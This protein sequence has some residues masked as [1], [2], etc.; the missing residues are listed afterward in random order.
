MCCDVV[1]WCDALWS[2]SVTYCVIRTVGVGGCRSFQKAERKNEA[3]WVVIFFFPARVNIVII[4]CSLFGNS[5][6]LPSFYNRAV[7]SSHVTVFQRGPSYRCRQ[8]WK[9][10]ELYF[11]T[12][13]EEI[14]QSTVF[15][16]CI[17]F[18]W[19]LFTFTSYICP[20]KCV[21]S[22]SDIENHTTH[23]YFLEVFSVAM[24]FKISR[25][26]RPLTSA[27]PTSELS[28]TTFCKIVSLIAICVYMYIYFRTCT[29]FHLFE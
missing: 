26:S 2:D 16:L 27:L 14:Y 17:S 6:I 28:V 22:T 18:F 4:Y 19:L 13:L 10:T 1:W 25:H 3:L 29:F 8:W 23:T 20:Q 9:V 21:I 7:T 15:C 24:L 12:V 5:D 11:V